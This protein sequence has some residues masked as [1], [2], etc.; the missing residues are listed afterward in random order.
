MPA[1]PIREHLTVLD[2]LPFRVVAGR[3]VP[4]GHVFTLERPEE[5][6]HPGVVPAITV[7]A[8][9]GGD[10]VSGE[11]QLVPRGGIRAAAIR[12]VQEPSQWVPA[13]ERHG[14]GTL[15]EIPSSRATWAT[16]RPDSRVSRTASNLN[17]S[18]N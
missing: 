9:T 13:R 17:A 5:A 4:R 8:H 7:A 2:D 16:G 6:L 15:S 10:A 3:V 1:R 11:Q 12:V 18:V 14:E